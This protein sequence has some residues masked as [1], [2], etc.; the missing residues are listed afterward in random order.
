MSYQKTLLI[1][2]CCY[3]IAAI[4][5]YMDKNSVQTQNTSTST[6]NYSNTS[7]TSLVHSEFP[8]TEIKTPKDEKIFE[9]ILGVETQALVKRAFIFMDDNNI[10]EAEHYL[11]QALR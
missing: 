7:Q 5:A 11:E 3:A 8:K 4:C 9:P 6:S 2:A 10:D 1:W